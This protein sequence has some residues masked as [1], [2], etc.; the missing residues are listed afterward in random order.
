[1]HQKSSHEEFEFVSYGQHQNRREKDTCHGT[2]ETSYV[3]LQTE[4]T[5]YDV[6]PLQLILFKV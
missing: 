4:Y 3:E 1:M 2:E 6:S 5:K